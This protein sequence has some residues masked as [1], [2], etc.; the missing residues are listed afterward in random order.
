MKRPSLHMRKGDQVL[1]KRMREA[2]NLMDG[3]LYEE[4]KLILLRS[5]GKQGVV[6]RILLL[7]GS[8]KV[9]EYEVRMKSGHIVV[10]S[11]RFVERCD[12][13]MTMNS[14]DLH[15]K[16]HCKHETKDGT[17]MVARVTPQ[18]LYL[19]HDE[20]SARVICDPKKV[21]KIL[22]DAEESTKLRTTIWRNYQ[23]DAIEE[24]LKRKRSVCYLRPGGGKTLVVLGAF[25]RM[26]F[27]PTCA[28]PLLPGDIC[29]V[30]T[31]ANLVEEVWAK[32]AYEHGV[33]D[34][35]HVAKGREAPAALAQ[36]VVASIQFFA[37]HLMKDDRV[38]N[39]RDC[40]LWHRRISAVFIDEVHRLGGPHVWNAAVAKIASR[41]ALAT[42]LTGTFFPSDPVNA[43]NISTALGLHGDL[44]K[45]EFW[46]KPMSLHLAMG[47]K[48]K[49]VYRPSD[50]ETRVGAPEREKNPPWR[51]E[52]YQACPERC[53]GEPVVNSICECLKISQ[54]RARAF[55]RLPSEAEKARCL[56]NN[57]FAASSKIK[58]FL[59]AVQ[60]LF[61]ENKHKLFV[62][63]LYLDVHLIVQKMLAQRYHQGDG[64]HVQIFEY[65]GK[66]TDRSRRNQLRDYLKRPCHSCTRSIMVFSLC[67]GKVGLNI[68]NGV[69]SPMAHIEFEQAFL[70]ADRYQVLQRV[71][72]DGNPYPMQLV[73]LEGE[74]TEE[75]LKMKRQLM[76]AK[77]QSTTGCD[78]MAR[79][80]FDGVSEGPIVQE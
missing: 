70:A 1:L 23:Q 24:L 15:V 29:L 54:S 65:S 46:Q 49:A 16:D 56:E 78:N 60:R 75:S 45:E 41:A 3:L 61:D 27:D 22:L 52:A 31:E 68:T 80:L 10:V 38:F 28:V 58:V 40:T 37:S 66:L 44:Q 47:S 13:H 63:V 74:E 12:V 17:F 62:T 69:H 26:K 30:L 57:D 4:E 53:A 59:D 71:D 19:Q 9:K 8:R 55:H 76:Q 72:R 2:V 7:D 20:S 36:L 25:L 43:A 21:L 6:E 39:E 64:C 11:P 77:R 18:R 42:G 67:A 5:E 51:R 48:Y 35:L 79:A 73:V 34:H 14:L 32:Q 33:F 50:E